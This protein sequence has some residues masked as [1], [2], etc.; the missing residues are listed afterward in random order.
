MSFLSEGALSMGQKVVALIMGLLCAALASRSQEMPSAQTPALATINAQT[1]TSTVSLTLA[2]AL[3]RARANSPQ[4][5]AALTQLGIAREDRV[6]A[7]AALLPGVD[8]NN[9]FI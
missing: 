3:A 6:Q 4:F 2:D 5:Q 1:P 7:R 8:Y 9:G